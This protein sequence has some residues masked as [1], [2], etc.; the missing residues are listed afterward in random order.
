MQRRQ[1][2]KTLI[3]GLAAGA[4]VRSFPFRVFSFP[5]VPTLLPVGRIDTLNLDHLLRVSVIDPEWDGPH[6]ILLNRDQLKAF[7][8]LGLAA[9]MKI[10]SEPAR[11]PMH[12]H[13]G[14]I[15]DIRRHRNV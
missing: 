9:A 4:A 1:F 13:R 8:Q 11:I 10:G 7:E 5:S 2:L 15:A 14:T 3:G 12:I 6:V